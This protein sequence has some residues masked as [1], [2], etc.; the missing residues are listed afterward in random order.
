MT[1]ASYQRKQLTGAF[2]TVLEEKFMAVSSRNLVVNRQAW[3]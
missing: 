2:F 1:K 3:Y